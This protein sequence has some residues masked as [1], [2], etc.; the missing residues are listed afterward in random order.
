[1]EKYEGHHY[2]LHNPEDEKIFSKIESNESIWALSQTWTP[3][4]MQKSY[5]GICDSARHRPVVTGHCMLN[6][7]CRGSACRGISYEQKPLVYRDLPN[8]DHCS[9]RNV[10][11]FYLAKVELVRADIK[12]P[13]Y[14][15]LAPW[16]SLRSQQVKC[17]FN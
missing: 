2:T 16:F 7:R 15:S 5:R 4:S 1:M 13:L 10:L 8:S 12:C 9:L 17:S 14:A 3:N 6:H 11:R